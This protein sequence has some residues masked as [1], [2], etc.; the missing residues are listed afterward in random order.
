M[1]SLFPDEPDLA[2]QAARLAPK[3][4]ELADQGVRFGT[5]SWKYV[6]WLGSIYSGDL[7]KT[8]GKHSKAKFERECLTEYARVFP[9][10]CGDFVFY[11]FPSQEY[12][13]DL[14]A[15]TPPGFTFGLKVPEDITVATWPK[16][17]RYGTR[18]G[19]ANDHFLNAAAFERFF[20][21][22]LE[23]HRDQLGPLIIEFGTFNKSTFPTAADFLDRLDPFLA[24]LPDGF[25]YSVELRNPEY[26]S[27][28]YFGLLA[29]TSRTSSMRGT[30]CR[31]WKIRPSST[32]P[33]RPT[34]PSSGPF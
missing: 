18:A 16:H 25:R 21:K 27:P 32:T 1:P 30:G 8:R 13:D 6:G 29:A 11:Q 19:Q 12:W 17:A 9:T 22:R 24:A 5:S 2:P 10:V 15:R 33:S 28:E 26:L 14:F 4:H 3:L 7:Y 31:R 34:S 23:K 20:L